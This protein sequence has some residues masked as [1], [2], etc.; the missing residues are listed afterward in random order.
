MTIDKGV[1]SAA[2]AMLAGSFGREVDAAVVLAY[3]RVLSPRM[4]TQ[5]FEAAV[6]LVIEQESFWPPPAKLLEAARAQSP[7]LTALGDVMRWLRSHGGHLHAPHAEF[8][9]LPSEVKAGVKA[10]GG[11]RALWE[12]RAEE[13]PRLEK[14][15]GKAFDQAHAESLGPAPLG[16]RDRQLPRE[17]GP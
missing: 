10:A 4:T 9:A 7:A 3:Y 11:L 13:M 16:G 17:V 5:E 2:M 14:R 6:K 1:F 8:A 12:A 15:F